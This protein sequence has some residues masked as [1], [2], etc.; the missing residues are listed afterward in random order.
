MTPDQ[1]TA[2][3]ADVERRRG[4]AGRPDA[5]GVNRPRQV[6]RLVLLAVVLLG[7]GTTAVMAVPGLV[8]ADH[9]YVV[10]SSSMSPAIEAG[11]VV[12]VRDVAP[13]AIT[14]GDVISFEPPDDHQLDGHERVTHRVVGAET[15]DGV[16]HFETKGDANE[17]ADRTPVPATRVEG[18][19]AFAIPYVGYLAVFA[20]TR[21]G[22][23]AL[24]VLPA[25]LLLISE[26]HALYRDATA[27]EDRRAGSDRSTGT[28]RGEN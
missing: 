26:V 14:T 7:V 22:L 1:S 11:D 25:T 21:T 17:E 28:A 2:D 16:R 13:A 19:V 8:G 3:A 9:S 5:E 24:V 10:E 12:V 15:V 20:Q 23:L 4:D 27:D 18:R 6:A